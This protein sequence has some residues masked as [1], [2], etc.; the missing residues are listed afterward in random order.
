MKRRRRQVNKHGPHH[1]KPGR[2]QHRFG[3]DRRKRKGKPVLTT[4]STKAT[5]EKVL[6]NLREFR[7]LRGKM[8]CH[9][10]LRSQRVLICQFSH[11]WPKSHISWWSLFS[12]NDSPSSAMAF[13]DGGWKHWP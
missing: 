8:K 11:K 3:W 9:C 4:K 13:G 10:D 7:V 2:D 5:K 12:K 1:V 6:S